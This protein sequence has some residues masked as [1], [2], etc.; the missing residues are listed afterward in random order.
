MLYRFLTLN[1]VASMVDA[2]CGVFEWMPLLIR[3]VRGRIRDF[4]YLGLDVVESVV[5]GNKKYET[6]FIHFNISN[7]LTDALPENVDFILTRDVLM[8]F[9]LTDVLS[10]LENLARAKSRFLGIGSFPAYGRNPEVKTGEWFPINLMA[11]PF[12]LWPDVILSEFDEYGKHIF[13]Y[14]ADNVGKWPLDSIR[15]RITGAINK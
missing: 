12:N 5:R 11:E 10:A 14:S 4:N 3:R 9:S 15:Q 7:I 2:P 13:I 8:H 6:N 1:N